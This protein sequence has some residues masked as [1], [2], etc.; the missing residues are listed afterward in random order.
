MA[1]P[2]E[3][4]YPINENGIDGI[5]MQ[6][7]PKQKT[8]KAII[9]SIHQP[10]SDI[11]Q[12]FSHIMLMHNG[13]CVFQGTSQEAADHFTR[14]DF[15][16]RSLLR[17]QLIFTIYFLQYRLGFVCPVSYNPAD[18]YINLLSNKKTNEGD[19]E[20]TVRKRISRIASSYTYQPKTIQYRLNLS[21]AYLER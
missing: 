19:D 2:Q 17:S 1:E 8:P 14:F 16:G 10:T 12:C 13:R 21:T 3:N 11:F 7:L 4:D 5:E 15:C 20:A 6:L 9:C 18:F